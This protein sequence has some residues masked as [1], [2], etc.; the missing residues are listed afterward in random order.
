MKRQR[1]SMSILEKE[2]YSDQIERS[3]YLTLRDLMMGV[4]IKDLLD[5]INHYESK[6]MYE[7]CA[8][9]QKALKYANKKTY[10]QIKVELN[11]YEFNNK[12]NVITN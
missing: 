7:V 3:Y 10:K 5:D 8:G 4:S 11:E 2:F 6:E 12:F 1:A 9:I